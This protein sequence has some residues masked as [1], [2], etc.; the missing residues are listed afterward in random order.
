MRDQDLGALPVGDSGRLIGMITDRDIVM[1]AVA[2]DRGG[3]NT[4][5]REVMSEGLLTCYQDESVEDAA[6]LMA[7]HRLRRV[8]VIDRDEQLVG[9]VSLA[10]LAQSFRFDKGGW[11]RKAARRNGAAIATRSR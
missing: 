5:V 11:Y 8:S 9:I 2:T 7:E 4:A 10:H 6:R 1:R 3:G